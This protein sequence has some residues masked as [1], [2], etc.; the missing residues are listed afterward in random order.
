MRFTVVSIVGARP[1]FIKL[2]P[3]YEEFKRYSCV[4]HVVLHTGQ[5]YD[6]LMSD[7][8]FK[9]FQMKRPDLNLNIGSEVHHRQTG[10][11]IKRIG[12]ELLNLN[13]DLVLI[14]GDTNTTLAGAIASS[15]L[16]IKI[17]HI[18]AGLRSYR[19][20]MPE[21]IN[22]VV[23]DRLSD[24]LFVPSKNA[25]A[26]LKKEGIS[27]IV[28][29]KKDFE[30]RAPP[31]VIECGDL[32]F[33]ILRS[34]LKKIIRTEKKVLEKYNL[35]KGEF[36]L[37]TVHRAENTDR[38]ENLLNILTALNR[39]SMST[40]VVFPL[41]PRTEGVIKNEWG[42]ESFEN[43]YFVK[44]LSYNE[45]IVL[46]KNAKAIFTDSGGVQKEAFWLRVPCVTMREETEWMET[47]RAG[48]NILTGVD[49]DRIF[50][51]Y[52][53]IRRGLKF[54]LSR[55]YIYGRGDSARK[56]A[57]YIVTFLRCR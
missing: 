16:G 56:I 35:K 23:A 48:F 2:A 7:V 6:F 28:H 33:D 18:E 55:Y 12:D 34:V 4:R 53:R 30:K 38:R 54:D 14:Y 8:F 57:D 21:E 41:H 32:M 24:L 42:L 29:G 39:I 36:I 13:P 25:I 49:P 17:A 52:E 15:K 45:M 26:N 11:M 37:S 22:R 44:P 47:I 1:Q 51:A 19:R 27:N 3:I 43:I 9:N 40:K 5:H 10:E 46:E 20:D 31:Y 50:R